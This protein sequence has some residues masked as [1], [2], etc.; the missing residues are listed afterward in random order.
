[1]LDDNQPTF[2]GLD[3]LGGILAIIMILGP[4]TLAGTHASHM[5]WGPTQQEQAH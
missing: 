4:L 5:G 2:A 3:I 1:M